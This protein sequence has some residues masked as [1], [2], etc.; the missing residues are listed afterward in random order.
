MEQEQQG[1]IL[2]LQQLLGTDVGEEADAML[3]DKVSVI[4]SPLKRLKT[5][6]ISTTS[7]TATTKASAKKNGKRGKRKKKK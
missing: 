2:L 4:F 1:A 7:T 5:T 6:T 3:L